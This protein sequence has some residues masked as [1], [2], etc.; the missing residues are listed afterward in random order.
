VTRLLFEKEQDAMSTKAITANNLRD[1]SVV[2]YGKDGSWV[3]AID[4]AAVYEADAADEALA[5][6]KQAVLDQIVVDVYA[7]DV[8]LSDGKPVP[9]RYR[10]W[11]R[12]NGPSVRLDLGKQ[13][14]ALAYAF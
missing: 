10:E 2:W 3:D 5:L 6:A 9:L 7:I 8:K 13:A 14:S 11:L 1:G 4:R 12:A